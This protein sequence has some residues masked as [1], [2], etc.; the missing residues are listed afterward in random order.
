MTTYRGI[1]K[2]ALIDS[3]Q[4]AEQFL[5]R[6]GLGPA[7][8]KALDSWLEVCKPFETLAKANSEEALAFTMSSTYT[9]GLFQRFHDFFAHH[10]MAALQRGESGSPAQ[11][12][13]RDLSAWNAF[14]GKSFHEE[15]AGEVTDHI[16][17]ECMDMLNDKGVQPVLSESSGR[18]RSLAQG[19]PDTAAWLR[20][21]L[22]ILNL[23]AGGDSRDDARALLKGDDLVDKRILKDILYERTGLAGAAAALD[24][25]HAIRRFAI[26]PAVAKDVP[27]DMEH[28]LAEF[29]EEYTRTS[30]VDLASV[31]LLS[32]GFENTGV[33]F[34]ATSRVAREVAS[35]FGQYA[36]Y[37]IVDFE[38]QGPGAPSPPS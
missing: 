10:T 13:Y 33:A 31:R 2:N 19:Y 17:L 25:P 20:D 36:N 12:L 8:A 34:R 21:A 35:A 27:T 24:V 22:P 26:V 18:M 3:L 28:K 6:C 37:R 14:D 15:I 1:G 32:D 9:S 23:L 7:T 29:L 38:G 16:I 11:K 5:R 30:E 4:R